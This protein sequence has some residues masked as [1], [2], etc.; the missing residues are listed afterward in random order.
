MQ[1][2]NGNIR[3]VIADDEFYGREV[4]KTCLH[5]YQDAEIV[6]EANN[7]EEALNK[8]LQLCPDLLILDVQMPG[9][10]GFEVIEQIKKKGARQPVII[11]ITAY[12]HY[13]QKAFDANAVD[14]LLK[15]FDQERFDLAF[16][17]AILLNERKNHRES[18]EHDLIGKS[19]DVK[20]F[21]KGYLSR[22]IVK[23]TKRIF[24][25]KTDEIYWFE[26]S[27]DYVILHTETKSH[28]INYRLHELEEKLNQEKFVRIHRSTIVNVDFIQE[29]EPHFN[30][31]YFITLQNKTRLK[32]SRTFREGLK[33]HF[34]DLFD[35]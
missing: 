33:T 1:E 35:L 15:P 13:A 28:L 11:F 16:S 26:A 5:K 6:G 2:V 23:E 27:G 7:G 31:E 10:T 20:G 8:V 24:Y 30:G 9:Y 32:M 25:V 18:A 14:Y 29:F 19:N 22:V 12:D 4:I 21:S 34:A 17:K 3:V